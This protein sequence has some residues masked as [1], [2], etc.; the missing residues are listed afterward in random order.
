M[1]NCEVTQEAQER[2]YTVR[3]KERWLSFGVW[4]REDFE[5]LMLFELGLTWVRHEHIWIWIPHTTKKNK[6]KQQQKKPWGPFRGSVS[7]W[8]QLNLKKESGECL[9]EASQESQDI[10]LKVGPCSGTSHPVYAQVT[11]S[12][13]VQYA[14]WVTSWQGLV[15]KKED[16]WNISQH[17]CR[18]DYVALIKR[19]HIHVHLLSWKGVLNTLR[20]KKRKL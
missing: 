14:I 12:T 10:R 16:R 8:D 18:K 11:A 2:I 15:K 4:V 17:I 5:Q 13:T 3:M 9:P 19:N 7:A 20:R 6:K 1:R